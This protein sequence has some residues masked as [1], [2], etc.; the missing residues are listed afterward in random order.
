MKS[1]FKM[2]AVMLVMGIAVSANAADTKI[3]GRLYADWNLDLTDGAES[4]NSFNLSRAYV[5][6]KSKLSDYTSVRITS[7]IRQDSDIYE[8]YVV[9]LKYGYIDWNPKF[10]KNNLTFRFGLQPTLYIDEMNKV[11]NR[12]YAYKVASDQNKYLT[13]GDLGATALVNLGEKG[14]SGYLALQVLNGTS[15][16]EVTE[17]NKNKN[18]G[19]FALLNPLKDNEQY[20]RSVFMAQ[21]YTGTQ[22]V[23]LETEI[24]SSATPV[25]IYENDS[26]QFKHQLISFGGML[27]ISD[28]AD[29]GADINLLT[30][31]Q[32]YVDSADAN[33]YA[34]AIEDKKS[35]AMSFFGTW[36]F[37][38]STEDNSL[39]R[40]LNLFGRYDIVDPDTDVDNDG[41]SVL[42]AGVECTPTSGFK[43]SVNIRS[44]SYELSGKD[45]QTH[46]F[47]NT[48]FKF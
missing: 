14:K 13:S 12:R 42:I 20:K 15:Y 27:G 19:L 28:K 25:I 45:S 33:G 41:K 30:M 10:G 8:G 34:I 21:F 22:N 44:T 35:S 40:T 23:S 37:G 2:F 3:N 6:V 5:T 17:M 7:D 39:F 31:G 47:V 16:S 11:W 24:D 9:I 29:I 18:F 46:L 48:L 38:N 43:A 32:G 26:K 1:L 4:A 36:Y